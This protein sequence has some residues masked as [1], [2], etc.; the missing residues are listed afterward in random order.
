M[1]IWNGGL[2][3]SCLYDISTRIGVSLSLGCHFSGKY[4][5]ITRSLSRQS[6]F[7]TKKVLNVIIAS[8][9]FSIG[10]SAAPLFEW[11]RIYGLEGIR[12][13]CSVEQEL[14]IPSDKIYFGTVFFVCY[15][16]AMTVITFCY[17]RIH[18]LTKNIVHN[19][20]HVLSNCYSLFYVVVVSLRCTVLS[21][22][23]NS[24]FVCYCFSQIL[25]TYGHRSSCYQ[26]KSKGEASFCAFECVGPLAL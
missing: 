17:Y 16:L 14:S 26:N 8:W 23:L 20:S 3:N 2:S 7:D 25:K 22:K 4:L 13:T 12:K 15:F 5:T 10:L 11:S 19:T 1:A 6:Y 24:N 9:I 18:H 21:L